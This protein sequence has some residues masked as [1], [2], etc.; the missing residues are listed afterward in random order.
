[1]NFMLLDTNSVMLVILLGGGD[2]KLLYKNDWLKGAR[3]GWES[4]EN[5]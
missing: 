1:M 3:L 5:K 4:E 2:N